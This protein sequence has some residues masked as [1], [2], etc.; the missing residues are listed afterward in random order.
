M[1]TGQV[2][3][4][5]GGSDGLGLT[6]ARALAH[7]HQVVLLSHNQAKLEKAA[8]E[9]GCQ[10]VCADVTDAEQVRTAAAEVLGWHRRIDALVT[11]AGRLLDGALDQYQPYEIE[12]VL[13][14]NVLGTMLAAQAVL[15]RMKQLQK[16]RIIAIGSQAGLYGRKYRSVY[17]ASKWALRGFCA[18]LQQELVKYGIG[19]SL[20]QPGLMQTQLLQKAGVDDDMSRGIDPIQV[21]RLIRVIVQTPAEITIPEISIQT[22]RDVQCW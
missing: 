1:T 18:S 8:A 13:N 5:T 22:L 3:L 14:I 20:I 10:W 4:I 7:A 12:Q 21:A 15:P 9:I 19:V 6:T 17:N 11:C 16:G 2:I